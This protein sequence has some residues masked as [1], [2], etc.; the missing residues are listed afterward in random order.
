[1]IARFEYRAEKSLHEQLGI[2]LKEIVR[3]GKNGTLLSPLKEDA[4]QTEQQTQSENLTT[5]PS[6]PSAR[7][8]LNGLEKIVEENTE[9]ES[10]SNKISGNNLL[11]K[12]L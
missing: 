8:L 5:E 1:M 6:L 2:D 10:S 9:E 7:K 11:M 12:I 4:V 3:S